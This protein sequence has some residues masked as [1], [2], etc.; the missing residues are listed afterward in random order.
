VLLDIIVTTF[1][2]C[3]G[4]E[5]E[6]RFRPAIEPPRAYSLITASHLY[7]Y[8]ICPHRVT[9]DAFGDPAKREE[10]NAFVKLLWER[11]TLFELE[12]I[13][14]LDQPFTDLSAVPREAREDATRE[15]MARGDALIYHGRISADGLLGEPDL[16]RHEA[17][18]LQGRALYAAIDIKSGR[19]DQ[20]DPDGVSEDG[21][22]PG[23]PKKHYGVQVA[24]YTDILIRLERSAGRYAYIWDI[25]GKE[26]RYDLDTP[27]GTRT[28]ALWP[29]YLGARKGVEAALLS[30]N[31]TRAAASS[32]CNL[33]VWR[34]ECHA[35]LKQER[36]LS[37]LPWVGRKTRD[38]LMDEFATLEELA[39][40][41]IE[42]YI[43][44]T[45]A[46]PGVGA[47]S[48]RKFHARAILAATK[49]AKPYLKKAAVLPAADTELFFDIETFP[50]RDFCYLHGFV[51]RQRGDVASE[52]FFSFFADELSADAE[53]SAF[54]AAWSFV[55]QH[56]SAAV[57]VYSPFERTTY[58][59]LAAKYPDVCSVAEVEA[60][61]GGS[62]VKDLYTDIVL[63]GSEWP[64]MS[65][66][67]KSIAK[68]L[69][70]SWRDT[71]PSGAASIEWFH[72]Y[73]QTKDPELRQRILDYNEDDCR[74]MRVL[75]DA[76][77]K[78]EVRN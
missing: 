23:K 63:S 1:C 7:S 19:G 47:D 13:A 32:D 73:S 3:R 61:F 60:F 46:L 16:L 65:F 57:Y 68:F 42:T 44:G 8:L 10:P 36:D 64:T 53:R 76:I 54:R 5:V 77:K 39:G 6:N 17:T 74:A 29:I 37:L 20:E 51:V 62:L 21:S 11:G 9:M 72:R 27:L 18:D 15:A 12:T 41:N 22:E 38:S 66:S 56:A 48:L 52:R 30:S 34:S 24:L 67:I 70:F 75:V 78:L 43:N 2:G 49:D 35:W 4:G 71:H 59:K 50:M 28:P 69:G 45:K 40:A 58:K 55:R 26:T 33:C 25:H 14:A 31:T